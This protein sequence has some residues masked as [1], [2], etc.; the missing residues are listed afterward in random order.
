MKVTNRK[1]LRK[2]KP[3]KKPKK[4][5]RSIREE[6]LL[7]KYQLLYRAD[8]Y[9]TEKFRFTIE[10]APWIGQTWGGYADEENGIVSGAQGYLIVPAGTDIAAVCEFT[11]DRIME[12]V[13]FKVTGRHDSGAGCVVCTG[14]GW[15]DVWVNDRKRRIALT[16]MYGDYRMKGYWFAAGLHEGAWETY[17]FRLDMPVFVPAGATVKLR[18]HARTAASVGWSQSKI[19]DMYFT[20]RTLPDYTHSTPAGKTFAPDWTAVI[21]DRL[22]FTETITDPEN[23]VSPAGYPLVLAGSVDGGATWFKIGE[24]STSSSLAFPFEA[25]LKPGVAYYYGEEML[26]IVSSGNDHFLPLGMRLFYFDPP[27]V[28]EPDDLNGDGKLDE[29]DT[30]NW[31]HDFPYDS[32][33]I[34][35]EKRK[36]LIS[37]L[38]SLARVRLTHPVT[39]SGSLK[40]PKVDYYIP[41]RSISILVDGVD[42]GVRGAT[43]STGAYSIDW[44]PMDRSLVGTR[45]ISVQS[46][47]DDQYESA[48]S[49]IKLLEIFTSIPRMLFYLSRGKMKVGELVALFGELWDDV[50]NHALTGVTVKFADA[51]TAITGLTAT[52]D[53]NGLFRV[54]W[55]PSLGG[56]RVNAHVD[57]FNGYDAVDSLPLPLSTLGIA[58]LNIFAN[59]QG[60]PISISVRAVDQAFW[61]KGDC[62]RDGVIDIR[63]AAIISHAY[64]SHTGEPN[65]N[66]LADLN[67]D[68][69]IDDYD[70][71]IFQNNYGDELPT[72]ATPAS[73]DVS[74]GLVLVT[75]QYQGN[76][77]T[78]E[79]TLASG[80]TRTVTLDFLGIAT[81]FLKFT[82]SKLFARIRELLT[83]KS[84]LY[85]QEADGTWTP[86]PSGT[87]V[88]L[89]TRDAKGQWVDV[90]SGTLTT[91][92]AEG[93]NFSVDYAMPQIGGYYTFRMNYAG[94]ETHAP[95]VSDQATINV[96]ARA[97]LHVRARVKTYD[98]PAKVKL[99]DLDFWMRGDCNMDGVINDA[100]VA[101]V[102][103]AYGS[104]PES[105]NWDER[106]DVNRD[107]IVDG[108]DLD[109]V[110]KN[111]GVTAPEYD[112]PLDREVL[113]GPCNLIVTFMGQTRTASVTVPAEGYTVELSFL[114]PTS[115]TLTP[116]KTSLTIGET[117]TLNGKLS[118]MYPDIVS[119]QTILVEKKVNEEW[120]VE[121]TAAT[122]QNGNFTLHLPTPST[123][124][125]LTYRARFAE[126]AELTGFTSTPVA[127]TVTE[128]A[129]RPV[130]SKLNLVLTCSNLNPHVGEQVTIDGS[131]TMFFAIRGIPVPF[132]PVTLHIDTE[133]MFL[134]TNLFGKFQ[135]TWKPTEAKSYI[136]Y[137]DAVRPILGKVAD[138]NRI[139]V[140]A[141]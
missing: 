37:I 125:T 35:A 23:K 126:T 67:S 48:A 138:S 95:A 128:R 130:P 117:I 28:E 124:T 102:Q 136:I 51:G 98:A 133:E 47:G 103:A 135:Y 7:V 41:G 24:G 46:A 6:K 49:E 114:N 91:P 99:I 68:G 70:V 87:P 66:P 112:A 78:V 21:K 92:D 45:G 94:D 100:D 74:E 29:N 140:T 141:S 83:F 131:L 93:Y 127:V 69:V 107:L 90:A 72:P 42:S 19:K 8:Q 129:P 17:E 132:I 55:S 62:T 139:T 43:G 137:A 82:P 75:G 113:I 59:Y 116:S 77:K 64:G 16:H 115:V 25:G 13:G 111:L 14:N 88:T 44:S 76:L 11:T 106:A 80:E 20:Y 121:A 85:Y 79:V 52:T 63:D 34:V 50:E 108:G 73:V 1:L 71:K 33:S 96:E 105:P 3:S 36:P 38:L 53:T 30:A 10:A 56:H 60:S 32:F 39:L 31:P 101:I 109:I 118:T 15:V 40:D 18:I 86:M 12:I 61:G 110:K 2:P 58:H 22:S 120:D 134:R 27:D 119:N 9:P 26:A 5:S 4:K 65:Y 89:Q 122:D 104:R 84:G 57:A 97:M 81:K 123:P 54:S